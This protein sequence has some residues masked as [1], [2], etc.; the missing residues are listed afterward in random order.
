MDPRCGYGM[1]CGEQFYELFTIARDKDAWAADHMQFRNGNNHWNIFF[2]IHVHDWEV[3]SGVLCVEGGFLGI[4]FF[5][6][7]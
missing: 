5:F 6:Y 2:T 3:E 1:K 7:K 4:F